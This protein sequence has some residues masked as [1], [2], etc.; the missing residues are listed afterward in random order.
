MTNTNGDAYTPLFISINFIWIFSL[1]HS[2]ATQV[3]CTTIFISAHNLCHRHGRPVPIILEMFLRPIWSQSWL[4]V[5]DVIIMWQYLWVAAGTREV[6]LKLWPLWRCICAFFPSVF[7][8]VAFI[9]LWAETS[10]EIPC[11]HVI[12]QWCHTHGEF[13]FVWRPA[14]PEGR[15]TQPHFSK[16]QYNHETP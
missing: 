15:K 2:L 10:R 11:K 6:Y 13:C 9:P 4:T 3:P 7:H 5:F 16:L 12:W 1:K 14:P 8:S